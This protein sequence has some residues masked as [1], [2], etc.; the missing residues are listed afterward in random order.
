MFEVQT[1]TWF[2][3]WVNCWH[4]DDELEYFPTAAAAKL[5]LYDHFRGM[6]DAGMSYSPDDYRIVE[7][8]KPSP[9]RE[10]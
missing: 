4:V 7:V 2:D 1:Y 10:N 6:E 9:N 5:E 3:G 8:D